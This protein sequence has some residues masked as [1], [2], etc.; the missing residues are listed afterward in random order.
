MKVTDS[1]TA[2]RFSVD[3]AY[4][5]FFDGFYNLGR[6]A[7]L[8]ERTMVLSPP[9]SEPVTARRRPSR[10]KSERRGKTSRGFPGH[11]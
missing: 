2:Q 7:E 10:R 6:P 4:E 1:I 11:K 3:E 9:K 8:F 5:R